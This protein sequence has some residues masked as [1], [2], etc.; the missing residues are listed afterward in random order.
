VYF[1]TSAHTNVNEP[2]FDPRS[3]NQYVWV[4]GSTKPVDQTPDMSA[5]QSTP[6]KGVWY[7]PDGGASWTFRT[8]FPS[9]GSTDKNVTAMALS[10]G[11]TSDVLYAVTTKDVSGTKKAQLYSIDPTSGDVAWATG[12]NLYD[13]LD[14]GTGQ[15]M[16]ISLVRSLKVN[17]ADANN[18]TAVTDKGFAVT[19]D[20][21]ATWR[22]RSYSSNIVTAYQAIPDRINNNIMY[23]GTD[24]SVYTTSDQGQNWSDNN[25]ISSF[26]NS[27]SVAVNGTTSHAVNNS[28]SGIAKSSGGTWDKTPKLVGQKLFSGYAVEINRTNTA[29]ANA[30]GDSAG[31]AVIY[32][33]TNGADGW[34]KVFTSAAGSYSTP[35]DVVVA[36]PKSNS[37]RVYAGG[38]FRVGS[39]FYNL[40]WSTDKGVTWGS[41]ILIGTADGVPVNTLAIDAS[42]GSSYS[43]TLYA[44][45]GYDGGVGQGIR[46]STDGGNTWPTARQVG[47]TIISV[48]MNSSASSQII[49]LGSP[50]FMWKSTDALAS[51]PTLLSIPFYG[52]KSIV[53]HPSYPNSANYLWI[54]TGD[55]QNIYKTINSGT[56]WSVINT[57]NVPKP[58][59]KICTDPASNSIIY[60]A[61]TGGVYNV[62]P[63]P[64]VPTGFAVTGTNC[65]P[66]FCQSLKGLSSPLSP[67]ACRPRV[68]WSANVEADLSTSA[69]YVL[70]RNIDNS[71]WQSI[72]SGT[73]LSY[74]DGEV[75]L[76]STG[77][78][79]VVYRARAKDAGDNFSDYTS[80]ICVMAKTVP[81][82]LAA[83]KAYISND[84]PIYEF[85]LF[86]NYPNPFNPVTRIRYSLAEQSQ[87]R[88]VVYDILGREVAT[89][90]NEVQSEGIKEVE[91]DISNR[92][93][94]S[95]GFYFYK[96]EAG[97]FTAIK[98]MLLLR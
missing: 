51:N 13:A 44:G 34:R 8:N 45:L 79:Y 27:S 47:D 16:K 68:S 77:T 93:F 43:T 81:V 33:R 18:L 19:T 92:K 37:Q 48:A 25:G 78:H 90:I 1:R 74:T 6:T 82:S 98:K 10:D 53:M 15:Q 36:D 14:A 17:P 96:L 4:G 24:L 23:L 70:E 30:V 88:L 11:L 12:V 5:P 26:L 28:Y 21:G 62:N 39:S 54:L 87:V 46:K 76:S 7:S 42:S 3:S 32:A 73:G 50:T 20:R 49:Y 55:G 35:F 31:L 63:S 80:E 94:L 69:A 97:K 95:S 66:T 72:S 85:Q 65:T 61:T 91:F 83:E 41:Q 58:I 38:K 57:D 52:A 40:I 89:L 67:E 84:Q 22:L 64:E 2:L 71:G 86:G 60:A 75:A 56:T 29:Y 9:N 59:N